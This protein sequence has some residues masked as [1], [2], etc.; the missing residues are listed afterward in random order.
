MIACCR[1]CQLLSLL[2]LLSVVVVCCCCLLLLSVVVDCCCDFL[3][4]SFTVVVCNRCCCL[5]LTVVVVVI[6]CWCVLAL[7]SCPWMSCSF[8]VSLSA[9]ALSVCTAVDIRC[10]SAATL[11]TAWL[12]DDSVEQQA[13]DVTGP[14]GGR[15]PSD[16]GAWSSGAAGGS[17]LP[18][19][20]GRISSGGGS[21]HG[22]STRDGGWVACT[23]GTRGGGTLG[24]AMFG[25]NGA[26]VSSGGEIGIGFSSRKHT[27]DACPP[28]AASMT[29]VEP[30]WGGA[31]KD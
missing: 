18:C 13:D 28:F 19:G 7:V 26:M 10:T 16:P 4:S 2:S 20:D 21:G 1:C 30:S 29:I 25:G 23:G 11:D 12:T 31:C 27:T 22:P 9:L 6:V 17:G 15:K 24:V 14:S 8:S 5:S 3:L